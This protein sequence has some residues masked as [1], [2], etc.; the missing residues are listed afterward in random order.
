[1]YRMA[2]GRTPLISLPTSMIAIEVYI[3]HWG[4]LCKSTNIWQ[5]RW[6][7]NLWDTYL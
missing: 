5:N 1:M 7:R 6:E 2:L 3:K 4:H